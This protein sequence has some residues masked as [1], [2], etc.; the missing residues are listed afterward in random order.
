MTTSIDNLVEQ[1]LQLSLG[2]RAE[3]AQRIL[4]SL[5]AP[6]DEVSEEEARN[7]W[8]EVVRRRSDDVHEGRVDLIDWEEAQQ[9]L[10]DRM[11]S[12]QAP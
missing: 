1:A 5:S 2:E 8:T 9:I 12:R 6:G 7:A 4:N 3:L 11:A 10:R